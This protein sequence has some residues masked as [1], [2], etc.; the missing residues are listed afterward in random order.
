[1]VVGMEQGEKEESAVAS[2][3]MGLNY[4]FHLVLFS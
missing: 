4:I 2:S 1:M 3:V